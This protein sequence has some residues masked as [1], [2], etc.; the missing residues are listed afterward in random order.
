MMRFRP[1]AIAIVDA[2]LLIAASSTSLLA[3][4]RMPTAKGLWEKVDSS[5]KPEAEFRITDCNGV[6]QGKIVKIFPRPGENPSTF[7]CTECEGEQKNAPV[8][9]LTFITGMRREGLSY[10][11][12]TILDPRDGSVYSALMELS[13]DG[14]TLTIRGYLGIPLLGRSEVWQRIPDDTAESDRVR[15]CSSHLPGSRIRFP[16]MLRSRRTSW[17]PL[18]SVAGAKGGGGAHESRLLLIA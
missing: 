8:I 3:T 11:D 16:V 17:S 18:Q 14:Q 10:R 4:A 7:R 6:Y 2:A 15:S 13:P 12:G 5:G 1:A 9:G